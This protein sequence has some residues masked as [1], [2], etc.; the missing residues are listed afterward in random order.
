MKKDK[1][2]DKNV[3]PQPEQPQT[4]TAPETEAPAQEEP[5]QEEA[6]A[7][8]KE[9]SVDEWRAALELAVKQRDDYLDS[10]RRTQ[11]DFQ[12]FKRRNQTARSDGYM[13]GTCDVIT[14]VLPA[15]DNLERALAAAP[16]DDP[17]AN[18]VRMTL[19]TL[20]DGMKGFGFEEVPAMGED[21]DPEKHNAVMR[22]QGEEPGKVLEVFQKGYKV[23]DKIIRYAMVK[24][25]VE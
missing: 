19:N 22:E 23:K 10:L 6:Q 18:G 4:E 3:T 17:L 16:E 20:L 24:V 21:F 13:D 8:E 15:I 25:S 11:A 9:A 12:N 5:V 1:E 2:K 14:A 7:Q